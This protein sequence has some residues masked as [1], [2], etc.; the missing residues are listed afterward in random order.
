MAW[1]WVAIFLIAFVVLAAKRASLPVWGV[2]YFVLL[3]L[4]TLLFEPSQPVYVSLWAAFVGLSAVLQVPLIRRRLFSKPILNIFRRLMPPMSDTERDALLAGD[5]SWEGELFSG[6]PDWGKLAEKPMSQLSAQ[7]QAF[8]DGPVEE[9]CSMLSE[10]EINHEQ[11]EVPEPILSFIKK[12][13]FFGMIIPKSYGGLE[14][15]AYGHAQVIVKVGAV[16]TAVATVISV[17]NS[18]GP[19]ELLLHYGTEKEKNYYL[20]RLAKGEEIPC[21]ALTSPH[22]GSDAAGSMRDHGVVCQAEFEGKEQLCIRLTWSKRYIT[23]C[24]IATLLGLA[25]KLYDPNKLLGDAVNV[26]ITCALIP[27]ATPGVVTGRRHY[28]LTSAFPN[29][30]TEGKDVIIPLDWV[31]GGKEQVGNGWIMLMECLAAGRGISLPSM[32]TGGMKK[33]V[34]TSGIYAQVREQFGVP[35]GAFDGIQAA[36]ATVGGYAFMMESLRLFVLSDLDEGNKASVASA[37]AK[38]YVTEWGREVIVAAMDI[39]GGKAIC[40]GPK[41]Y[42]AQSY[43]E[44]PISITVEGAN[45]LTRSLIIFGQGLIRC[46]P[47]LY[48]EMESCRGEGADALASFDKA[49]FAHGGYLVSN[50][51]RSFVLGLTAARGVS[52]T[53]GKNKR[54]MQK[55]SRYSAALGLL[56]DVAM[57]I[58][59]G[60]LKRMERLSERMGAVVGHLYAASSV[61][62]FANRNPDIDCQDF[63]DWAMKALIS[64]TKKNIVAF[65]HN[66]PNRFLAHFLYFWIFPWGLHLKKPTDKDDAKI[67][68]ALQTDSPVRNKL[69]ESLY[70]A[71][72]D[73]NPIGEFNETL[74]Q[75]QALAPVEKRLKK[76]IK[77]QIF[78][79]HSYSKWVAEAVEKSIVTE[80][81]ARQ[82]LVMDKRRMDIIHVDDFADEQ[83]KKRE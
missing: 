29:G 77:E 15:S 61:L 20:P 40:M 17:P 21:F 30:P 4:F 74:R 16:C 43:I 69:I 6:R 71:A 10:W 44:S 73:K 19:A 55:I 36:L 39:H 81:E 32:A 48:Q 63:V 58:L 49:L 18:L 12:S 80:E 83:L 1:I 60:R 23:L 57:G 68:A 37:I 82:L 65:L 26:G 72:S 38:A 50:T 31:I 33:A 22:A 70:T 52:T 34:F 76:A 53:G 28:P 7:E 41:N 13:G 67:A 35:I 11:A 27:V 24:P 54:Y 66:F 59:G 47:Y 25:F 42:L 14:F 8:M 46:H 2:A 9:L 75:V 51:V 45:I 78:S 3:A 56:S 79:G 64:E 5:V 62:H